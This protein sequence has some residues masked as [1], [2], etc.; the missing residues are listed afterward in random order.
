MRADETE[1][2]F[3]EWLLQIGNAKNARGNHSASPLNIPD[4]QLANNLE[5]LISF[6]FPRQFFQQPFKYYCKLIYGF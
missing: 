6:C 2:L 3:R 4:A 5:E 1:I